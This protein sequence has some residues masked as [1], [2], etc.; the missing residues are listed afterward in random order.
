VIHERTDLDLDNAKQKISD[1]RRIFFLGFGYAE[2]NLEILNIPKL[3]NKEQEVYGTALGKT[4]KEIS[5]I[6]S[7][8]QLQKDYGLFIT[9]MN[10]Y[11]LLREFL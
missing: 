10:C 11:N 6:K 8:M 5:G 1:A 3:F 4:K 2:E 9:E 7:G